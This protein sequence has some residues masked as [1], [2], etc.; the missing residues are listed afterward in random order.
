MG[1]SLSPQN[2]FIRNAQVM[3]RK[4]STDDLTDI[5]LVANVKADYKPVNV[6]STAGAA[7]AGFDVAI[8]AEMLQTD[9]TDMSA[10]F[11]VVGVQVAEIQ[12]IGASD[13]IRVTNFMLNPTGALDFNGG[14]S[15]ITLAGHRKM[16]LA[17]ASA[18]LYAYLAVQPAVPATTVAYTN[19]G[20]DSIVVITGGTVTEIDV[21]GTNTNKTAGTFFVPAGQTITLT[22]TVAPTWTW[23]SR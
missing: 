22:Y 23:Y 12:F 21:N 15:K 11:D 14:E 9:N 20:T 17:N 6:E 3:V 13:R 18:L 2:V 1:F 19:A 5:G 4:L 16:T 8:T 10:V 7:T